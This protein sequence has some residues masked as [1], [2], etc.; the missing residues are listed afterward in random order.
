MKQAILVLL[1]FVGISY[2]SAQDVYTSSGKTGYHK[3]TNK[4]KGFD[5]DKLILGGGVNLSF[6]NGYAN[7]GITPIVGYRLTHNLAVGVGLGYQYYQTPD[8]YFS[9]YNSTYYDKESIVFPNV[10]AR[11]TVWRGLYV[12]GQFEYD[13]IKL[14]QPGFDINS[15]IINTSSNVNATCLLLGLGIKFRI[16]GRTSFFVEI[17]YDVLQQQ[18]SPYY[19][20]LVPHAGICVGL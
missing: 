20:Q 17:A 12:L 18:W 16:A 8:P 13:F 1:L 10:W 19:Q 6:G 7:Y 4:K 2:A 11:Y 9:T 3:K 5:P 14:T 15:N